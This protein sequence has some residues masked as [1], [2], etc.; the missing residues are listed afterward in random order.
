MLCTIYMQIN[1]SSSIE[2]FKR[3]PWLN[4]LQQWPGCVRTDATPYGW[5]KC[6]PSCPHCP[7]HICKETILVM[8]E[9]S[10]IATV[11][12]WCHASGFPFLKQ[13]HT[14]G[15]SLSTPDG[16]IP[17]FLMEPSWDHSR[18]TSSKTFEWRRDL[19]GHRDG[20]SHLKGPFSSPDKP[21][22]PINQW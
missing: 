18:R 7:W 17:G 21:I 1:S 10:A 19:V 13:A 3:Q 2:T 20:Q 4:Y 5:C 14:V 16:K 12:F 8:R 11:S 6:H 15:K 22:L 9:T